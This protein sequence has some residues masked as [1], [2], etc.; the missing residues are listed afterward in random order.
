MK[1]MALCTP[2]SEEL[3]A[4]IKEQCEITICGAAKSRIPNYRPWNGDAANYFQ[5]ENVEAGFA[6]PGD[7]VCSAMY[8]AVPGLFPPRY[9]TVSKLSRIV[10]AFS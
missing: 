10:V 2:I 8:L 7:D 4:P 1:K 9:S 6:A 3:L 5:L